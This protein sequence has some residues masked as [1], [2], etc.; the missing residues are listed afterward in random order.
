M[1]AEHAAVPNEAGVDDARK[2]LEIWGLKAAKEQKD[3]GGADGTLG[4]VGSPPAVGAYVVCSSRKAKHRTLHRVGSC[5]RIPGT[6][7]HSYVDVGTEVPGDEAYL[8]ICQDCWST[9]A[10]EREDSDQGSTSSS[11]DG[12]GETTVLP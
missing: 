10:R 9:E 2:A 1:G 3:G 6:H 4:E 12:D 8:A 7:Y 5:F 11:S